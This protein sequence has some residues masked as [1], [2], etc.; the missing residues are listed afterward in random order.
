L[1]R[2]HIFPERVLGWS[3][4]LPPPPKGMHPPPFP[5]PLSLKKS[6]DC[7]L[8]PC[9]FVPVYL[10]GARSVGGYRLLL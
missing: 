5:F 9:H 1:F 8:C 10:F 2:I 7:C 6:V 4:P 3:L